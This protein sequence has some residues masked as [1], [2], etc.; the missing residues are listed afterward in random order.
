[1]SFDLDEDIL[2]DFLIEAGE[3][4][5]RLSEQLV[6]LEL[7][8]NNTELLNAIFRGFH[9]IKGGAGFLSFTPLVDICH[10]AENIF[11]LL[12]THQRVVSSD[13]MDIILEALDTINLMFL[14]VKSRDV[15]TDVPESLLSR[16]QQLSLRK[17]N[18][19]NRLKSDSGTSVK[20]S[21]LLTCKNIRLIVSNASRMMSIK[22]EDTTR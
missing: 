17:L 10:N 6:D 7:S 15:L 14:Q 20:T 3:I 5:E 13:L 19:C 18:C 16:L 11:D 22:S 21:R 12:R 1:M 9:T 4:L 8:P 2:Q